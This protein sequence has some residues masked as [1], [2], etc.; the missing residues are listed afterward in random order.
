M[1]RT[2]LAPLAAT[3]VA[4]AAMVPSLSHAFD[5]QLVF[6]GSITDVSCTINGQ[7]PG[8]GNIGKPVPMNP[9]GEGVP[10][11]PSVFTGIGSKSPDSPFSLVLAGGTACKDGSKASISFDT[12]SANIDPATGNLILQGNGVAKG[13]QIM[14][15]DNGNGATGKIALHQAQATPQVATITGNTATLSFVANYVQTGATFVAGA[16]NSSIRYTMAYY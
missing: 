16:A 5:G 6:T 1:K 11:D 7:Q 12:S 10:V 4:M 8:P 2:I 15:R 14:I 9:A 13:V 3:C